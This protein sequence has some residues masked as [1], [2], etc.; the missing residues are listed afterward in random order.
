MGNDIKRIFVFPNNTES[1][2]DIVANF[3]AQE[4]IPFKTKERR[5]PIYCD[6]EDDE[7]C[8]YIPIYDI[9]CFTDLQHFDFVKIKTD[10]KIENFRALNK[11]FYSK[12]GKRSKKVRER[13]E[14]VLNKK[15]I[16]DEKKQKRRN[17]HN[18][19]SK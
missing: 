7:P 18:K 11:V 5:E 9:T 13:I 16:N 15:N 3:L 8:D 17:I 4:N 12:I 2:A 14:K 10:K 19:N 1:E 6:C